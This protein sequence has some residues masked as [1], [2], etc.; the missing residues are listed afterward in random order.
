MVGAKISSSYSSKLDCW[1][2]DVGLWSWSQN[3]FCLTAKMIRSHK[4]PYF[5]TI[6][7]YFISPLWAIHLY[8]TLSMVCNL[9]ELFESGNIKIQKH[10]AC[11][12][13]LSNLGIYWCRLPS[14]SL[15]SAYLSGFYRF[16]NPDHLIFLS[17]FVTLGKY[18]IAVLAHC[19]KTSS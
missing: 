12:A 8:H 14:P 1:F 13:M 5:H 15:H 4:I 10:I 6:S 2:T 3:C 7:I 19:T 16:I 18:Y 17:T 11:C 9:M